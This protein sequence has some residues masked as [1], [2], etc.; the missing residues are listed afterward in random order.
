MSKFFQALENAEKERAEADA[1]RV[2]PMAAAPDTVTT[3]VR[4]E[5]LPPPERPAKAPAPVIDTPRNG[6]VPEPIPA[7]VVPPPTPAR[8]EPPRDPAATA[9]LPAPAHTAPFGAPVARRRGRGLHGHAFIDELDARDEAEAGELEEHLVSLIEPTSFAAEQ[10]RSV[11]LAIETFRRERGLSVVGLSSAGRGEGKTITAVNLAGALAQAPDMRIVLVDADLRHP[12][13]ADSLGLPRRAGL[14]SYLLDQSLAVDRIIQQPS[15]VAFS[16]VP[17]GPVSSMPYELLKSSRLTHLF[18][19][20]RHRFDYVV[21]DTPPVLLFPDVGILRDVVD[22]FV[23]VVRA[24][25]TPREGL[26]DSLETLGRH[27]VVG[28]VFNDDD[29][30]GAATSDEEPSA[31]WLRDLLRPISGSVR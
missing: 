5:T 20:L 4:S 28:V 26:N 23:L 22:G 12:R 18:T 21:V 7:E 17:A 31:S 15:G 27:R 29:R 16:V 10:Y 9:T 6:T 24:N 8:V 25:R 30:H 2:E 13:V 19:T 1:T 3:V 11:R 14:S